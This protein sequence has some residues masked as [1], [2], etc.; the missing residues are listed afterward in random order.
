MYNYTWEIVSQ[1]SMPRRRQYAKNPLVLSKILE[2]IKNLENAGPEPTFNVILAEL[3]NQGILTFHRS[4]RKYL[5]LLVSAK[6]LSQRSEKANQPNIREKQVYHTADSRAHMEAGEKSLLFHGLNWD[7]PSPKSLRVQ[8]D[9]Q[10]LARGFL[11]QNKVYASLEDTIVQSLKLLPGR[12]PESAP[13]LIVFVTALLATQKIDLD[14]LLSRAQQEGV[15]K[16]I[17][18]ILRVIEETFATKNPD[19][20]DIFTLYKLRNRYTHLHKKPLSKSIHDIQVISGGKLLPTVDVTP[21]QVVEYSGK[22]LGIKG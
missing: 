19:V 3:S 15:E 2:T 13:E 17:I 11:S 14:Y 22:Q 10:A 16:Q 18:Q 9:L 12:Y 6:L 7:I 20:E 1:I 5:D 4:L 21:N 8:T